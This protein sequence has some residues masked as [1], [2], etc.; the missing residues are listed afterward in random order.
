VKTSPAPEHITSEITEAYVSLDGASMRYLRAG[1]GPPLILVHGLMGHSFS[2]RFAMPVFAQNF[3]VYAVDLLGAGYSDRP[4]IDQSL[5]ANAERLLRF[6]DEIG[7]SSCVLLG[8]SRG[9]GIVMRAA[10]LAPDR[11][12][13][14]VLVSPINPWSPHGKSIAP[15]LSHDWIAPIFS[16]LGP[17]VKMLHGLM[18]R[19]LY[20]DPRRILPGTIEGYAGPY[21]LAKSFEQEVNILRTW[22]QDLE[23]LHSVL[24]SIAHIPTLLIWGNRDAAV[25]PTSAEPLRQKFTNCRLVMMDGVGHIPYEEVPD[26]FNRVVNEFLLASVPAK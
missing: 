3:T 15:V 24:P 20:G 5:R 13:R 6:L 11:V 4:V 17:R 7:A 19:R 2:W 10:A 14:M 8:S 18:L 16:H 21:N 25:S 9:G 12:E 22:N 23:E 1:S 26:E